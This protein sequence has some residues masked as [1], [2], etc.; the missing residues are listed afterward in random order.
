MSNKLLV[1]LL[2][3][4]FGLLSFAG[5][6]TMWTKYTGNPVLN[7]GSSGSWDQNGVGQPFIIYEGG[8]YH[9]WYSGSFTPNDLTAQIGYANSPDGVT[10]SKHAGNPVFPGGGTGNWDQGVGGCSVVK[11]DTIFHMW[12]GGFDG[13]YFR[14]GHAT[15]ADGISWTRDP[16]NPVLNIG[17]SGEWDD[18][19]A[20]FPSVIFDGTTFNMW[21]TGNDGTQA[22][23]G[24][25]TSTD[26]STWLKSG[27]PVLNLG[28]SGSWDDLWTCVCS[29]IHN[30]SFYE[31]LYSGNDNNTIRIGYATSTDGINWNKYAFNPVLDVGPSGSWEQFWVWSP[32]LIFKGSA[33]EMW[34][35][36]HP[37]SSTAR[38]GFA[39][40]PRVIN[41]PTDVPTIQAGIDSA[42]NGDVVL[43]D[44]GTYYENINFK[45]KAIT[46]AS[47]FLVDG[48]T[49]HISNTIIDGSQPTNPDSG[50]VVYIVSEE[51]STTTLT[52]F[53]ITHGTGTIASFQGTPYN[54]GGGIFVDSSSCSITHNKIIHNSLSSRGIDCMGA[55]IEIN[56]STCII[57]NNIIR[58]NSINE[59]NNWAG[60]A[61]IDTYGKS[62]TIRNNTIS[63]NSIIHNWGAGGGVLLYLPD[64]SDSIIFTDNI[65]Q[66]NICNS[67]QFVGGGG[68]AIAYCQGKVIASGN[69]ITHNESHGGPQHIYGEGGGVYI[70]NCNPDIL[71]NI[72][73][74]NQAGYAAGIAVCYFS[75]HQPQPT[76]PLIIN[77]T[78]TKNNA[79]IH[80]GG[81]CSYGAQ[82]HP[83]IINTILWGDSAA[84][85]ANEIYNFNGG[86]I[87]V[88]YSDIRGGYTGFHNM[89]SDPLFHDSL[90]APNDT[91]H[92]CLSPS[93]PCIDA[94][95]PD[96]SSF[97]PEDPQNSGFALWPAM[98]TI[99]CDMGAYGGHGQQNITVGIK[100][101]TDES[102]I[103]K[104]YQLYQNYPNPFN[105]TTTIQFDLPKTSEVTLKI[106][107]V[108]GEEV[109]TLLSGSLLS[110]SHSVEWDASNL[111]SGV[112]LY[113][114]QAGDY[115]ETRKM[116]LMR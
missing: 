105:P 28:P 76:R 26:G 49:S 3:L 107:N 8:I 38:I 1:I 46:V 75:G 82:A 14:T 5:S 113:R 69:L 67:S 81:L 15:S 78:I 106:F 41:V 64:N 25:A 55:G 80:G 12:Y 50:S 30:G 108:L 56:A 77:N 57:E 103:V 10:W 116:I 54:G 24:Y 89:N 100:R 34:Y 101:N 48:D 97:D 99:T 65:V 11:V 60:G 27:N 7:P 40:S 72:I 2:S 32:C 23:I 115:V 85:Q 87:T 94:G 6:Q 86:Q 111:A 51:D 52:G 20:S 22:R 93:S 84:G 36:G 35:Q 29:V 92:C 90:M 71:N 66:Q 21:Y 18:T 47:H 45:G 88:Q 17:T 110:G 33:Y 83:K 13:T 16:N 59:P 96:P 9:M 74:N 19:W 114:L 39:S 37:N 104:R 63:D 109:T 44:E 70:E 62:I 53:T 79:L 68:L 98:G 43:V 61:G 102:Q 73:T 58:Y 95:N 91:M 112:Y 31:M 4:I 42:S